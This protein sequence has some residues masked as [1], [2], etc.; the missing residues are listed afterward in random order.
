MYDLTKHFSYEARRNVEELSTMKRAAGGA[1]AFP[2]VSPVVILA[3]A[4]AAEAGSPA[5]Q[6]ADAL[7]D[8]RRSGVDGADRCGVRRCCRGARFSCAASSVAGPVPSQSLGRRRGSKAALRIVPALVLAA[9]PA[10]QK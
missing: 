2:S 6:G 7:A 1:A 4:L 5:K 3:R 8:A 10:V 9:A